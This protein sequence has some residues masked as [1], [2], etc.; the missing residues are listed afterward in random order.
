MLKMRLL[1]LRAN[2]ESNSTFDE[3]VRVCLSVGRQS[4]CLVR[5]L[6]F[7]TRYKTSPVLNILY[8]VVLPLLRE[9]SQVTEETE[10]T[11]ARSIQLATHEHSADIR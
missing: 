2:T 8:L 1:L 9:Y 6:L 5:T 7:P 10:H 3:S 4:V 11:V